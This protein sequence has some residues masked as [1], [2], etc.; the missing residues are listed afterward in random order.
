[1]YEINSQV[2][3]K[4]G[5]VVFIL[6]YLSGS[7]LCKGGGVTLLPDP[8]MS[9]KDDIAVILLLEVSLWVGGGRYWGLRGFSWGEGWDA[10]SEVHGLL[11]PGHGLI[12]CKDTK[13]KCLLNW[14]LI[15]FIVWRYSQS[16]RYF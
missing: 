1:M 5:Y 4:I 13:T 10:A 15:E 7:L 2:G 14:C 9:F 12:N 11:G 6:K 16:C 3:G 8:D